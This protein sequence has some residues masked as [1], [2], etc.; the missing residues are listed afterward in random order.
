MID[1]AE[2]DAVIDYA[3]AHPREW[4]QGEWALETPCGTSCCIAGNDSTLSG[5][6]PAPDCRD[7]RCSNPEGPA[8]PPVELLRRSVAS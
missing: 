7:G 6:G 1:F 8:R 2:L 4:N 3:E 5:H